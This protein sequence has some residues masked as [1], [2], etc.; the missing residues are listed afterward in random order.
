M[1]RSGEFKYSS[2]QYQPRTR[3]K[4]LVILTP[5]HL[6]PGGKERL[7][8]IVKV[9]RRDPD[10]VAWAFCR[11]ENLPLTGIKRRIL[12]YPNRNLV[13]IPPTLSHFTRVSNKTTPAKHC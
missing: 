7:I 4:R 13:I 9:A 8:S 1:R 12:G 11:R 10:P 3:W 5:R 6:T 2:I